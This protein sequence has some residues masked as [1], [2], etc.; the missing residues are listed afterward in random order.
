MEVHFGVIRDKNSIHAGL[1][2]SRSSNHQLAICF[3]NEGKLLVR[4]CT[5]ADL[6]VENDVVSVTLRPEPGS[7]QSDFKIPLDRI[8]SIYPIREFNEEGDHEQPAEKEG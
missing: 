6:I 7:Q 4:I 8:Q 2:H 3:N 5:V 1:L